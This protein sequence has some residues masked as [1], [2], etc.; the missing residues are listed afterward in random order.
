MTR[1]LSPVLFSLFLASLRML[2]A[3]AVGW[4]VVGVQWLRGRLRP[5]GTL[6]WI[7]LA[8]AFVA[9][10]TYG[11]PVCPTL[12]RS[13][14]VR[15]HADMQ[16]LKLHVEEFRTANGVYPSSLEELAGHSEPSPRSLRDC[17]GS[18]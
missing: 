6:A 12:L 8:S 16:V 7:T 10:G 13:K 4:L 14:Q 5:S 2:A 1:F 11:Y 9:V 18:S 3:L 17:W 15:R